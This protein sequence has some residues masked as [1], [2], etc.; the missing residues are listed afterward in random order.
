MKTKGKILLIDDEAEFRKLL[1]RV[2]KLEKYQVWD[3]PD[4]STGMKI[5]D[6]EDINV[7]LCD[8]MLGNINGLELIPKIKEEHPLMEVIMITAFGSIEDGV[9]AI[10]QGAFD[11]ITKGDEDN[12]IIPVIERALDKVNAA[13]K[14]ERLEN[15]LIEK[16]GFDNLV[17]NSA[18]L[19]ETIAIAQKVAST[20]T[21]VL[22][23]GETGTGKEIFAQSIHYS[24][25]RKNNPFVPINC[26][27]FA[28]ELLE[29][30]MFGYKTGAFTGANKD[31][32]GLFE[33]ADEGTLFL[34]EVSETNIDLQAKLLRAL[35]TK[36]F[37]KAG[38]TKSTEVDV[39]IIAATNRNLENE[40]SE[41]RFREDLYYRIGVMKIE[42]PPLRKRKEDIPVLVD[43]FVQIYSKRLGRNITQIDDEFM[44]KLKNYQFPGN[45]RELRN[46][47]E[48]AVILSNGKILKP[49]VLPHE[50]NVS[51][52]S[53]VENSLS[54]AHLSL[55]EIEK[56]HIKNV[57][58]M[59]QGNKTKAAEMLG[60][61]TATLYRKIES[62]EL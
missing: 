30:E 43:H 29:S 44:D 2:L 62:Y 1:T 45:I 22:L 17:G 34:D 15:Q 23:V 61:G 10:K 58:E 16:Y 32:K 26:S 41:G 49:D 52:K 18:L 20:D 51:I 54:G 47:I 46:I 60:I 28:R 4:D 36:S 7:V 8:V 25:P 37:I 12:Q 31:K 40:I 42:I 13:L 35:E 39:R 24:S 48:R 14:I 9:A 21:P 56:Q 27:A 50:V 3:A 19:R 6:K 11:Y 59:C 53:P 33:E 38:S 57:L 55:D 5:L